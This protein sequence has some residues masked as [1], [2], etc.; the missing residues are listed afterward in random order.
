L[1]LANTI[2]FSE[3]PDGN[4]VT[5]STSF[6]DAMSG[7]TLY[8]MK[9]LDKDLS[10]ITTTG[11][12]TFTNTLNNMMLS[13]CFVASGPKHVLY[14]QLGEAA[15]YFYDHQGTQVKKVTFDSWSGEMSYLPDPQPSAAT[16]L[17]ESL[18]FK[19]H[20]TPLGGYIQSLYSTES[21]SFIQG[22]FSVKDRFRSIAIVDHKTWAVKYTQLPKGCGIIRLQ[23]D[24]LFCLYT[25]NE[26]VFLERYEIDVSKL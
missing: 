4:M 25:R 7:G 12:F 9:V 2:N 8:G 5:C 3:L 13:R 22:G 23:D 16:E 14:A 24:N 19:D 26:A 21:Y 15:V 17:F 11:K 6:E 1:E 20:R 10:P 18:G